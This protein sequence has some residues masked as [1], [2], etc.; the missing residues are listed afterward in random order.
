MHP[1]SD[2]KALYLFEMHFVKCRDPAHTALPDKWMVIYR[3]P[4]VSLLVQLYS[5]L[6]P[7]QHNTAFSNRGGV[8]RWCRSAVLV[9]LN[10]H[11]SPADEPQTTPCQKYILSPSVCTGI[12]SSDVTEVDRKL[13]KPFWVAL[14]VYII[15]MNY[16]LAS[17]YSV[18][19]LLCLN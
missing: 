9:T 5:C 2:S 18:S 10:W 6:T 8:V 3:V 7:V 14:S 1:Y 12:V 15:S 13:W 4:S 19:V 16:I 17:I 11:P